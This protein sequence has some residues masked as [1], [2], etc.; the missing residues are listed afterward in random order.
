M[1]DVARCVSVPLA[2]APMI[3]NPLAHNENT[4][5]G[6]SAKRPVAGAA[7]EDDADDMIRDSRVKIECSLETLRRVV[8]LLAKSSSR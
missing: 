3:I 5:D 8:R 4:H 6:Q 7:S 1:D 2:E